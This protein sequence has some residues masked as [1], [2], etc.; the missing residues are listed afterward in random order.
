[1]QAGIQGSERGLTR[2]IV[3]LGS[4]IEPR[5]LYLSRALEALAA[6]P[7]TRLSA[8][9]AVIETEGVGV[10]EEFASLKFLNQV[11][12]LETALAAE[13]F[14]R[15]MHGIEDALGRVRGVRNG[16][17]T[18]DLDL[19]DFGGM[20]IDT[21]SLVLPHPRFRSRAFVTGPLKELGIELG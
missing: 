13:E 14:S 17:R 2:A 4:N 9:S 21:P 7:R 6:L 10:P 19:I 12:V 1:M 16:P 3:S 15:L 8:K 11:A 18:I 5:R 20:R